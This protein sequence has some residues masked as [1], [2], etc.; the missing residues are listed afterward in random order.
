[1]KNLSKN[2]ITFLMPIHPPQY[3]Y[4]KSFLKSYKKH[5]IDKQADF[6]FV[7]SNENDK[8]LYD[9]PTNYIIMP[10]E[11]QNLK[12]EEGVINAKKFYGIN[13]LKD[14]Y[15]YIIV[16]DS[17]SFIIKNADILKICEDFWTRKT[18]WGN[19]EHVNN[20][21]FYKIKDASE[22]W[23]NEGKKN[24]SKLDLWFNNLCIYRCDT[25]NDFFN[26]TNLLKSLNKLTFWDFDY[27]IYMFYLILY[28][29]FTD[30]LIIPSAN[31]CQSKTPTYD[32][33]FIKNCMY[34]CTYERHQEIKKLNGGNSVFL[35][36]HLDR[37]LN[38]NKDIKFKLLRRLISCFIPDK[39]LRRKI[40]GV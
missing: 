25:L 19:F 13:Q 2:K 17:E 20:P 37:K 38:I 28:H 14:K 8:N 18:L 5:K 10:T 34:M 1:M 32:E 39:F 23:F 40:R 6:Y 15:D 7:F 4:A 27:N 35:Y 29:G 36:I 24:I 3:N 33:N 16:I 11:L 31:T 30:K 21:R 22:C 12:R 26:K 9:N